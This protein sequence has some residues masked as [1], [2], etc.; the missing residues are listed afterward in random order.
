MRISARVAAFQIC[1]LLLANVAVCGWV[2]VQTVD[3]LSTF[4]QQ[5]WQ[6]FQRGQYNDAVSLAQR[7]IA[8]AEKRG[9]N[10]VAVP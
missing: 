5:V 2:E 10:S 7:A 8:V 1:L 3:E 4:S 9:P 6:L